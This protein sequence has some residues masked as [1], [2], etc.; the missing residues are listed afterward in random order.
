[1]PSASS[2]IAS[3][4]L[5]PAAA[6]SSPS[7][8]PVSGGLQ[9]AAAA[10]PNPPIS[11]SQPQPS[12]DEPIPDLFDPTHIPTFTSRIHS[13]LL[14]LSQ[15]TQDPNSLTHSDPST[16]ISTSCDPQ[17]QPQSQ[18]H[19]SLPNPSNSGPNIALGAETEDDA[20]LWSFDNQLSKT[21][22]SEPTQLKKDIVAQSQALKDA[23]DRARKAIE[24]LPGGEMDLVEQRKLI[25]RLEVC[26]KG[27]R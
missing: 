24:S 23:F 16:S 9:S 12:K 8:N 26:E 3:S 22:K 4:T 27:W 10:S 15:A 13:I 6:A 11:S 2:P 1:M 25:Q 20:H 18:A 19:D 7:L 14:L 21:Q 17:P 5:T